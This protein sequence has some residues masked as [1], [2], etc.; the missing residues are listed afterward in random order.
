MIKVWTENVQTFWFLSTASKQNVLLPYN[1]NRGNIYGCACE[2]SPYISENEEI[3]YSLYLDL[4]S[5]VFFFYN[6]GRL[7]K[8]AQILHE[9]RTL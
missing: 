2:K 6:G 9:V 8:N 7:N 4:D 5:Q 3:G 1:M